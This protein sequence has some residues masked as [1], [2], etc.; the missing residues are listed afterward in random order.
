MAKRKKKVKDRNGNLVDCII[1]DVAECTERFSE[2]KLNDGTILSVK[3][4][5]IEVVCLD[6][7]L[8]EDGKPIYGVKT[9][10]IVTVTQYSEQQIKKKV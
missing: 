3:T 9:Q 1:V 8:D 10:N 6:D 7:Q 5:I 2:A 4:N